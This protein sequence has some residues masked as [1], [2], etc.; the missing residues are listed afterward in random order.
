MG[1]KKYRVWLAP[2]CT[3]HKVDVVDHLYIDIA[4]DLHIVINSAH[5]GGGDWRRGA[6]RKGSQ[7]VHRQWACSLP[8]EVAL[9]R[10][11]LQRPLQ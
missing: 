5:G 1:V 6:G 3:V 11:C 2:G 9:A 8:S 7:G 4:S 10:G